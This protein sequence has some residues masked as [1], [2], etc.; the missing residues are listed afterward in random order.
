MK[1]INDEDKPLLSLIQE[2]KSGSTDPRMLPVELRQ[3]IIETLMI[4]GYAVSQIAQ[5]LNRSEKTI[6]RD[7]N[8]IRSKNAL[9]PSVDLAKQMIGEIVMKARTHNAYLMR[10]ARSKGGNIAEKAQAEY[11]AWRVTKELVEK[12]QTL[13]YLPLRPQEIVGDLFHHIDD[14][15]EQSLS[16]I[17]KIITELEAVEHDDGSTNE[18]F[19]AEVRAL[20]HRLSKAEISFEATKLSEKQRKK[21]RMK[22]YKKLKRDAY[23]LMRKKGEH[24]LLTFA[25]LFLP[26]QVKCAPSEAHKK[27]YSIL[28][29]E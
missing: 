20:K 10:L 16:E 6:Q 2:I 9:K 22:M 5:L 15:S 27:I 8:K 7:L 1:M 28:E 13:G 17:H 19:S 29:R 11:A 21:R 18:E 25:K 26:D 14:G 3:Q 24:S 23:R 4:E 12:L